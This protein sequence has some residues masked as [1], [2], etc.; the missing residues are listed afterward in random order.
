MKK[1]IG[2]K[3]TI[4][5]ASVI[6]LYVGYLASGILKLLETMPDEFGK[7]IIQVLSEPFNN[8]FND[9]TPILMIICLIIFECICMLIICNRT[10]KTSVN[11]KKDKS[12]KIETDE[13]M[14]EIHPSYEG[15]TVTNIMNNEALDTKSDEKTDESVDF[16]SIEEIEKFNHSKPIESGDNPTVL[17]EES[18]PKLMP[19]NS[20]EAD[21]TSYIDDLYVQ[22]YDDYTTDQLDEMV[23]VL[24]Y[25]KDVD[26]NTLRNM[27]PTSMEAGQIKDYINLFY[28]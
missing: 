5:M 17:T 27:F 1:D 28:G 15:Y 6:A 24:D 16:V 9:Y 22:L 2:K 14:E 13:D 4:I 19:G 7:C 20:I 23:R 11:Q 10:R 18:E 12:L 26:A 3:I 21:S 8:Y 25:M